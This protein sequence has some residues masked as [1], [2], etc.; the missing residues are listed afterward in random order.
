[1]TP[2]S[3]VAQSIRHIPSHAL[4]MALPQIRPFDAQ[5][6]VRQEFIRWLSSQR[7]QYACWQQAWNAWTRATPARPGLVDLT[8]LC[9]ECRGR[10]FST[11]SL[12]RGVPGGIC[13]RCNGQRRVHLR[14]IA[15][16]QQP[17]EVNDE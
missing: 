15:I 5:A 13:G 4:A 3:A 14:S 6:E 16:W 10:M 12:A 2:N 9:P 8:M 7:D 11:R 1:M 17:Q